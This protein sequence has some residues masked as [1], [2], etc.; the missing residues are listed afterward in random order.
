MLARLIFACCA[1]IKHRVANIFDKHGI[2]PQ[3]LKSHKIEKYRCDKDALKVIVMYSLG[4]SGL[5]RPGLVALVLTIMIE[6]FFQILRDA[7]AVA[8]SL[9]TEV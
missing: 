9:P 7:G 5:V 6:P 3:P 1:G 4:C 8:I 2:C